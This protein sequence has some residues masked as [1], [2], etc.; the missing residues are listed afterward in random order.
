MK[1]GQIVF[2]LKGRDKG[3]AMIVLSSEGEYAYL[4]D[5]KL[6][7]LNKP[8]KKKQKHIQITHTVVDMTP[9]CGRDLQDADIRKFLVK[10]DDETGGNRHCQKTM[11]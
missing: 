8:K 7:T 1:C 3:K 9:E 2:V 5:G 4:A 6:R 10:A 11:L